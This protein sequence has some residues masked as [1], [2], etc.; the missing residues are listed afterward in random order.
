MGQCNPNFPHPNSLFVGPDIPFSRE[1]LVN[2]LH[3]VVNKLQSW[4]LVW[5]A[6]LLCF[7]IAVAAQAQTFQTVF[8]LETTNDWHPSG[9]L[10]QGTG[11]NLYGTTRNGGTHG[12]ANTGGIV[13]EL[14]TGGTMT[15]LYNFCS[16]VNGTVCTD[17]EWPYGALVQDSDGNLY[18]TTYFGGG[19]TNAGSVFKVT[20]GGALTT[21]YDFCSELNCA[22]GS[23]PQEGLVQGSDGNFYGTTTSGGAHD[24]GG[25]IF[26]ITPEGTFTT[27]YSFCALTNCADGTGPAAL[28]QGS[29]GNFY[30][31]TS[32][33]GAHSAGTFFKTTPQG[34]LTTLYS[35]CSLS[36]CAD[37]AVPGSVTAGSDGNFY[38]TAGAGGTGSGCGQDDGCGTAFKLTPEGQLTTLYNFCPAGSCHTGSG[39]NG[40]AMGSDGN[41]YGTTMRGGTENDGTLLQLTLGG[42][43]TTLWNFCS[44]DS[45]GECQ[46]GSSP[47]S[48][49]VQA[50]NGTFYGTTSGTVGCPTTGCG[51]I[52]SWSA[53]VALDPTFSPSSVTFGN[54]GIDAT[55]TRSFV[56]KNVNTGYATLDFSGFTTSSPFAISSNTCGTTLA[57]GKS[58]TVKVTF[59]P[60]VLGAASGAVSI[61]DNAPG[62]PQNVTLSGTGVVQV[63]ITPTVEKFPDTQVGTTS[64]AKTIFLKNNLPTTLTGITYSTTGPFA[65]S[66]TTCATTLTSNKT[67]TFSVTFTPT[68]EGKA[69][70]TLSV[71]DSA[72]N[73][74]Q[75]VNLSGTGD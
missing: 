64:A 48:G 6:S 25:T 36:S 52:F 19:A 14:T 3:F 28:V 73:S 62:S 51:T 72:N 59:S 2:K 67:C 47:S 65:V 26:Q 68:A 49:I 21:L 18:G 46:D 69:T 9:P 45:G 38:G 17:G 23:S 12:D 33:G 8:N 24:S 61:A 27:L 56:I 42:A 44:D 58:C 57:A 75:I 13:F 41:L 35:F 32:G 63:A 22:D 54:Q 53:S 43:V 39:P 34:A 11:G 5:R 66:A 4:K 74:P 60:T 15:T 29:D 16:Q 70:G 20:L 1:A 37:G 30:G 31:T 7:A 40:L 55:G 71:S 10:I 50:S